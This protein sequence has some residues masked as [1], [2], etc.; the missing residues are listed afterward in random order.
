L[1]TR[2]LFEGQSGWDMKLTTRLYTVLKFGMSGAVPLFPIYTHMVW[3]GK[4]L[5]LPSFGH[6]LLK[7]GLTFPV[8][9]PHIITVAL[10]HHIR[11]D[12]YET[13]LRR[14]VASNG[15]TFCK[16][17]DFQNCIRATDGKRVRIVN[18]IDRILL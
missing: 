9:T 18:P 16:D 14:S 6:R 4:T 8:Q 17:T 5:L 3:T 7:D 10:I 2:V 1:G 15:Q 11:V 13:F 12:N